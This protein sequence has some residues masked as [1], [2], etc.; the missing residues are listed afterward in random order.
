[1]N[2]IDV[3]INSSSNLKLLKTLSNKA[4]KV[5]IEVRGN[6]KLIKEKFHSNFQSVTEDLRIVSVYEIPLKMVNIFKNIKSLDLQDAPNF[7]KIT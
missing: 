7:Q 3:I 2:D 4:K 5:K 1:L 6:K